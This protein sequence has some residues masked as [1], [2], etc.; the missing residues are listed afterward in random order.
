MTGAQS[1]LVGEDERWSGNV[2]NHE[3]CPYRCGRMGRVGLAWATTRVAPTGVAGR[4]GLALPG[5]PRGLPLRVWQ[6]GRDAALRR[7][8]RV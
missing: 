2:G 1:G 5:Q 8:G 7:R 3:G 6:D 4:R